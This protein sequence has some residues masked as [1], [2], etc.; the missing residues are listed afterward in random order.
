MLKVLTCI[1]YDHDLE[2]VGLA[3]LICCLA[4]VTSFI[5]VE[6]AKQKSKW[7]QLVWLCASA[8]AAGYGIWATHFIGMLAY[9]V[10]IRNGFDIQL[11]LV[12]A[13]VAVPFCAFAFHLVLSERLPIW[14]CAVAGAIAGFGIAAMHYIGM[15]AWQVEAVRILDLDYV[16]ASVVL[17]CAL[18]AIAFH[19]AFA[20]GTNV[21]RLSG[22][23]V[24]IVAIVVMHF[25][26]MTALTLQP[27]TT[28]VVS[29]QLA[30]SDFLAQVLFV[31]T[32]FV[33]GLGAAAATFDSVWEARAIEV[34]TRLN[35]L[36]KAADE[37][38]AQTL[39]LV[40]VA[41]SSD[42][43]V[44]IIEHATNKI[45]WA[46]HKYAE[47][48][49]SV[50]ESLVGK[51]SN[52]IGI[53]IIH[54]VPAVADAMVAIERGERVKMQVEAQ[55]PIGRK[56]FKGMLRLYKDETSGTIERISTFHDVTELA[57]ASERA[58][59]SEERFQLAVRGSDDAI[60]DWLP[61]EDALYV[62]PRG[63]QLLG[64]TTDDP[65]ITCMATI[66]E[67]IH[68]EDRRRVGAAMRAHLTERKPYDLTHRVRLKNGTYREFRARGQALWNDKGHPIRMAGSLS[69]IDDLAKARRDAESANKL[70]S[71][72]LANMSHE[73]RTPMNGIM[74]MCQLMLSTELS[75]K[76]HQYADIMLTSCRALLGILNDVLDLSKIEAGA[77]TLSLESVNMPKMIKSALCRV[78]GIA[79]HK[80]LPLRQVI[81]PE[82]AGS[83]DGDQ[84]RLV[85]VL[86]NLLGNA[87][88]FTDSGEITL[89]VRPGDAGRTRFSVTDTGI[90]IPQGQLSIV[91]E[92]FRQVD[93]SS[94]RKHG[95]TGL[96]LAISKE[97]VQLMKGTIGVE[98][99]D[100][101]GSTFWF[102][103][104]LTFEKKSSEPLPSTRVSPGKD[105]PMAGI[106]VLVA[107]DHPANQL[108]IAEVLSTLGINCRI[109]ENG[110]L[111][112]QALEEQTFD[113]VMLDMHMPEL[114]GD[115]ATKFIRSSE[116]PY[117]SVPIMI[118]T[119]DAMTGTEDRC[120]RIGANS[121]VPKPIEI[122]V[123]TEEI[124]RVVELSRAQRAA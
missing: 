71:Q 38:A 124:K 91:F 77:V 95:G 112:L 41:E 47:I 75:D 81:A 12:S 7:T 79:I 23:G 19:I 6:R 25:T 54:S 84:Q 48:V 93:G 82:C 11:T 100:G 36:A 99:S 43:L 10:H 62:S 106:E 26:G 1:A 51:L 111:A 67:L 90:G 33:L 73:I 8:V 92:R 120:L 52:S 121:F 72:F 63:H 13:V 113:L 114:N 87:I 70:K 18:S 94:T 16:V 108:I 49:D 96:G 21:R 31:V 24:L 45:L 46:N 32:L 78:E 109:V 40:A 69:D 3:A 42:D 85:Q 116:R 88:K 110:R 83:F 35:K 115:E 29:A 44:L 104:P 103:V 64:L 55:T 2:L 86:V 107:E 37:S 98:S 53:D 50:G 57:N 17:G 59:A 27:D 65:R 123:L 4:C 61:H 15:I 105:K 101:Q 56:H 117:A 20:N 28:V 118:L 68:P 66:T 30:Q 76:Q 39:R 122:S 74:G 102:E 119:A 14:R 34:R 5:L 58:R 97:L 89:D 9:I 22:A 60:W 80:K